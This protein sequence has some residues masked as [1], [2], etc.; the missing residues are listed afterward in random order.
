MKKIYIL[1]SGTPI[2]IQTLAEEII[3]FSVEELKNIALLLEQEYGIT[4]CKKEPDK[5]NLQELFKAIAAKDSQAQTLVLKNVPVVPI[6]PNLLL[7]N[8]QKQIFPP[9]K[10]GKINSKPKGKYRK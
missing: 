4:I 3:D 6:P 7:N 2:S 5:K 10:M 1:I 9:P 8:K